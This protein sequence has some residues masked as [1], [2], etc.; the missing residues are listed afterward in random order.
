MLVEG[1]PKNG[2]GDE[3]EGEDGGTVEGR[4]EGIEDISRSTLDPFGINLGL[5]EFEANTEQGAPMLG[6]TS[7][8]ALLNKY[9]GRRSLSVCAHVPVSSGEFHNAPRPEQNECVNETTT[10]GFMRDFDR[11]YVNNLRLNRFARIGHNSRTESPDVAKVAEFAAGA[12]EAIGNDRGYRR[13]AKE[14]D[15]QEE[16]EEEEKEKEDKGAGRQGGSEHTCPE[17]QS[18]SENKRLD[19]LVSGSGQ[20]EKP[21]ISNRSPETAR[22][23]D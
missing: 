3:E 15:E 1:N 10:F 20:N 4:R 6:Q 14:Q 17:L 9:G 2:S 11:R 7:V 22:P 13:S 18:C 23:T 8:G 5:I 16:E 21:A 19:I 12:A